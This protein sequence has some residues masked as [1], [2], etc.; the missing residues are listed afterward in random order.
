MNG[1]DV[2]EYYFYLDSTLIHSYMKYRYKY[3][4]MAYPHADLLETNRR[5]SRNEYNRTSSTCTARR[6]E[7]TTCGRS[8]TP[9]C[10]D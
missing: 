5:R 8:R 10:Y 3:P 4:Q 9:A 2:K 6:I 1:E 7:W